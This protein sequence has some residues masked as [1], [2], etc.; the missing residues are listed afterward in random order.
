MCAVDR[1]P[2]NRKATVRPGANERGK[3]V[4]GQR[5]GFVDGGVLAIEYRPDGRVLMTGPVATSFT[6]ELPDRVAGRVMA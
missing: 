2:F 4:L 6:G 5:D 3:G 1:W